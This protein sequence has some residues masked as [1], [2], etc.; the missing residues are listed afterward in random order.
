MKTSSQKVLD[1]ANQ[2][3]LIRPR[4]LSKYGLPRVTLARLVEQ[5]QLQ[6]VS[7]GLYALP[8]RPAS[9]YESILEACSKSPQSIVCLLTALRLH[10]LTTQNPFEVWL[11]IPN[12]SRPP[13][14]D[15][16]PLRIIRFSGKALE[17]GIEQR[18][19]EGI[20]VRITNLERTLVDCFKFRNK[21]GLDV[22]LEALR[23]AWNA[24]QIDMDKLWQYATT[25]RQSNVMRPYL[26]SLS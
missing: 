21:V 3:A 26:E 8:D 23:E 5:G 7:R 22:A 25:F 6:R 17:E 11:G 12:K 13:T 15:Y 1:L 16:P 20:D 19:I 24:K 10:E 2:Q 4:D 18:S 9:A 14:M